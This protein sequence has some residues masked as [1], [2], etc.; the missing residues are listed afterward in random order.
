VIDPVSIAALRRVVRELEAE[1]DSEQVT[2]LAQLVA[3][4]V[5]ALAHAADE[6]N[7]LL[8]KLARLLELHTAE[9]S[10]I[11]RRLDALIAEEVTDGQDAGGDQAG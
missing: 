7:L 6:T 4:L 8:E 10:S 3:V 2:L 1:A 11:R 9:A 5:D